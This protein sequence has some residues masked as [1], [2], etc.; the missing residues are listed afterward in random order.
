[1]KIKRSGSAAWQG[2]IKDGRGASTESGAYMP[3]PMVSPAASKGSGA[4]T[5]RN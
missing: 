5:R 1:M 4:A 2:G 3:I